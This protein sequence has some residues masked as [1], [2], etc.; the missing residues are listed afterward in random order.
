M[1][2]TVFVFLLIGITLKA[3]NQTDIDISFNIVDVGFIGGI[4]SMAHQLD[5]KILI[6]GMTHYNNG[7]YSKLFRLNS[8]GTIDN[9]FINSGSGFLGGIHSINVQD[10]GKILVCGGFISYN[11]ISRFKLMRLNSNGT[12]DESFSNYF[13]I[14]DYV[15]A[16][17][18]QPDGKILVGGNFV[19]NGSPHQ[20]FMIRLNNDGSLSDTFFPSS[21]VP[22]PSGHISNIIVQPDGKI[23]VGGYDYAVYN[24]NTNKYQMA[25]LNADGSFDNSFNMGYEFINTGI[26]SMEL[27][28]DGKVVVGGSYVEFSGGEQIPRITRINSNGTLDTSFNNGQGFVTTL[29]VFKIQPDNKILVSNLQGYNGAYNGK[30]SRLNQNGTLDE[31][32]TN[33]GDGFLYSSGA[34]SI[35]MDSNGRIYIFGPQLNL[36]NG[37]PIYG[38]ARL[39]GNSLSIKDEKTR[40]LILSPNPAKDFFN[41][42]EKA[43]E[44]TVY[45]LS[46]RVV[47]TEIETTDQIDISVLSNGNYILKGETESGERFNTKFIKN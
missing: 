46:G 29:P 24:P 25:R 18:I 34:A 6:A 38:I 40:K 35:E 11:G 43:K 30:I 27:N 4:S 21:A 41:L 37:I 19:Y 8:D 7:Y 42:S 28:S 15:T 22:Q 5:G 10:D 3:Q 12:L 31:T 47:K 44:I 1:K 32:F 9:T 14:Y 17:E 20:C 33:N 2:K 45:D 39:W 23:L 36:Y 26:Y 16:M 13:G